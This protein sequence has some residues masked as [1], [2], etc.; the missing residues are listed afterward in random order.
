MKKRSKKLLVPGSGPRRAPNKQKFFGSFFQKRTAFFLRNADWLDADRAKT[1]LLFFAATLLALILWAATLTAIHMAQNPGKPI[2]LDFDAF[3][4]AGFLAVH[5]HAASAYDNVAIEA[6]ERAA[7][8]MPPGYLAFYYPPPFLMLCVPLGFLGFVPAL[9]LF[10]GGEMAL[11]LSLLRKTLPKNF[12]WLPLLAWPGFLMNALSGQNAALTASCFAGAAVWLDRRPAL[13]G[14]CLGFLVC[15]PQLAVCVPVAL[16]AARRIRALLSC[17]AT[18][19][20]LCALSW[21][22]LG[23]ATWRGFLQNAPNARADIE[24]IAIKWPK[25]QSAFG[26]VRLAG[27]GNHAAYALQAVVSVL[28]LAALARLAWR[29]PGGALESSL[30]VTTALLFTPFLYDY[31]LAILAVPMAWLVSQAWLTGA[32]PWEKI[33]LLFLFLLP[34]A[35][36]ACGLLLGIIIG[37]P[38]VA[39]LMVLLAR[40]ATNEPPREVAEQDGTMMQ[41][42]PSPVAP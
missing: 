41:A 25:L 34:L 27:G 26:A 8:D 28:A 42:A 23:T 3:W 20:T 31:D 17:G 39:V 13:A 22:V 32:K 2:A 30:M 11:L 5:G 29:R 37:P 10:V 21:L 1:Y 35:A 14:A 18:A 4:A 19:L 40:R 12:P 6:V 16:L 7:T 15:K 24:T 38:F 33:L 9:I 36:R